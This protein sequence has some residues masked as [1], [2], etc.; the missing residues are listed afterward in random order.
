MFQ[1]IVTDINDVF[2]LCHE[3]FF[4]LSLSLFAYFFL[5]RALYALCFSTVEAAKDTQA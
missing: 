3:L 4:F 5:L 1:R 2:I